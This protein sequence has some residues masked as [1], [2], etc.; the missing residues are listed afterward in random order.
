M[1]IAFFGAGNMGEPMALHLIRAGHE[2]TIFNRTPSKV[3]SLAQAGANVTKSP[4]E[5]ARAAEILV[6]MLA[7][8][9][10]LRDT[11][12]PSAGAIESLPRGSVHMCTSTISV[13]LS[14]ELAREHAGRG[15]GYVAA[16][17]LGRPEA[18]AGKKLWVLAAGPRDQVERCRPVMEGI[19]RAITVIGEEAWRANVVKITINFMIASMI[20]T[21][22]EA[23]AL[24]RKHGIDPHEFLG[25]MNPFF[26]SP[27]YTNYG[28]IIAD[29]KFEPAGFRLKLGLKDIN[30][31]LAA[32]QDAAVPMPLASLIHD[33]YL[34]AIARGAED[35]DW[36]AVAEAAARN[37]GLGSE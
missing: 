27:I 36:A 26:D 9:Q 25:V 31:A 17:V 15:Q 18:A 22:G 30:L 6:T 8:D 11:I 14:K 4:A 1:K 34:G 33:H 7:D 28:G 23:F 10:A 16:P 29:R 20:E 13:A 3:A 37:A 24:A 21:I 35:A 2:I 32:A 12:L 5:A 19:G